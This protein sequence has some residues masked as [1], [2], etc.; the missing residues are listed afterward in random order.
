MEFPSDQ[1]NLLLDAAPDAMVTVDS[2]GSIAYVNT[3]AE[4]MFRYARSEVL[5]KPVEMLLPAR[6]QRRHAR[7]L[8]GFFVAPRRRPMGTGLEIVARRKDGSEFPAEVNLGPVL[9]DRGMFISSII[10]DVT[11]RK[12]IESRLAKERDLAERANRAKSAWLAI[13]SHDLKQPVQTL[14]LLNGVLSVEVPA[15]SQAATAVTDQAEVLRSMA[16]LLDALLDINELD[17]GAITPDF[18][19]CSLRSIFT[20]LRRQFAGLAE[21]KG[22]EFI[23]EDTDEVVRTD[24]T[25]LGEVI[26]NLVANAIRYTPTGNV[27]LHARRSFDTVS[28]EVLDTGIGIAADQLDQ[29]FKEF[30]QVPAA[31]DGERDGVGLGLSIARRIASLLESSLEVTSVPGQGSCFA[32]R[33]PRSQAATRKAVPGIFPQQFQ[34]QVEK[35]SR[36]LTR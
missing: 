14:L 4:S 21:D 3:E 36:R 34:D 5:G 8:Q 18:C 17:A 11:R 26:Q 31:V 6:L 28:I 24:P 12:E 33:V 2:S 29:I 30:Y 22:L 27:H 32:L 15:L 16:S 19:D 20:R 1:F 13:A 23:V 25:L 35:G 9:T 10:R 7:R